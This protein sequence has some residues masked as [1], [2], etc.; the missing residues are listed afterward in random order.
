METLHT[1]LLVV[2]VL[3]S[4]SLIGLILIQHGKGADAGAAFGSGASTTVFGAQGSGN[5]LSRTTAILAFIFLTNSLGL[6][7]LATQRVRTNGSLMDQ[8]VTEIQAPAAQPSSVINEIPAEPASAAA[9]S[10][11]SEVPAMPV[12]PAAS[13]P[14]VTP[15]L[16]ATPAAS[17]EQQADSSATVTPAPAEQPAPM[18]ALPPVEITVPE[19]A[20]PAPA[21]Q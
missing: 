17:V 12:E 16:D 11:S 1:I 8:P 3:V 5:F 14:A 21:A 2:Q 19:V 20:V 10:S 4:V 7:W 18:E 9:P 13:E 15:S 6:A